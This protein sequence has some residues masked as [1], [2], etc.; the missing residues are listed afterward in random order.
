MLEDIIR[1]CSICTCTYI[2]VNNNLSILVYLTLLSKECCKNLHLHGEMPNC[3]SGNTD[4]KDLSYLILSYLVCI[5]VSR[6]R[7]T[8]ECTRSSTQL[9][10]FPLDGA[11]C[12]TE[13][14]TKQPTRGT[15]MS[16]AFIWVCWFITAYF[17]NNM[18]HIITNKMPIY[19]TCN[20]YYR[21]N[22]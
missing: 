14:R 17:T 19:S 10:P 15:S 11:R 1:V 9:Q 18:P 5:E 4:N 13:K 7:G 12:A 2:H 16:Y 21:L 3:V 6:L 22:I 8:S 20:A